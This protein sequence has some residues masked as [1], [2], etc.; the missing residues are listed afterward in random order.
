MK[1]CRLFQAK[2]F[3]YIRNHS[4]RHTNKQSRQP[5]NAQQHIQ[6]DVMKQSIVP[7]QQRKAGTRHK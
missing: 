3:Q 6:D 2:A 5:I 4:F 1:V 7:Q